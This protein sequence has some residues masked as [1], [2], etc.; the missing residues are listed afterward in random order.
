M[1]SAEAWEDVSVIG[2]VVVEEVNNI[3]VECPV[4]FG[5]TVVVA[6]IVIHTIVET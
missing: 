6:V 3:G 5:H 1:V 2:D 4:S